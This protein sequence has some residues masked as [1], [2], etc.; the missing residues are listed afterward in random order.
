MI[1]ILLTGIS[2]HMNMIELVLLRMVK[3]VGRTLV[4]IVIVVVE[5]GSAMIVIVRIT[6]VM[7]TITVAV[8]PAVAVV[9]KRAGS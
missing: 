8:P 7:T 1:V 4:S 2:I 9:V 5:K 6:G 3:V